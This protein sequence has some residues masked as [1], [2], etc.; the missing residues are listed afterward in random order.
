MGCISRKIAVNYSLGKWKFRGSLLILTYGGPA[1]SVGLN[2]RSEIGEWADHNAFCRLIPV[3]RSEDLWA[4][5][6]KG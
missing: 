6:T 4:G 3:D 1:Q 5:D 2:S